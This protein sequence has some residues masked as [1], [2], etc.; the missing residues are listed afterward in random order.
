MVLMP[1]LTC[2]TFKPVDETRAF[3][4]TLKNADYQERESALFERACAIL[5]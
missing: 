5:V 3:Q 1:N 4:S 2:L